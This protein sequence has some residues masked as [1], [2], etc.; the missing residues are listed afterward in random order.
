MREINNILHKKNFHTHIYNV[1]YANIQ[2][3]LSQVNF[4]GSP[5]VVRP[6]F[7]RLPEV[8]VSRTLLQRSSLCMSYTA[9]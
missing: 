8:D 1:I 4:K 6:I 9:W 2:F 7:L 5:L 3:Q